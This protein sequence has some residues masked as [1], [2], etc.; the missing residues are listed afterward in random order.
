MSSQ[1]KKDIAVLLRRGIP[2]HDPRIK[3]LRRRIERET[4]LENE[5]ARNTQAIV[6]GI[7]QATEKK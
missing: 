4:E 5:A 3:G 1:T 2:E 6:Q 7:L